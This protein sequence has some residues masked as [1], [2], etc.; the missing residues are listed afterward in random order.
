MCLYF[1]IETSTRNEFEDVIR[2]SG[3]VYIELPY[4]FQW[5]PSAIV[6]LEP[7]LILVFC[8]LLSPSLSAFPPHF[9]P[10]DDVDGSGCEKK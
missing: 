5:N 10:S 3:I 6:P 1:I 7:L 2:G 8:S 9:S 4:I